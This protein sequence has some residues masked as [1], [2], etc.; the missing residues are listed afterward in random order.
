[1]KNTL[2]FKMLLVALLAT[3]PTSVLAQRTNDNAV[4]KAEDAFGSSVGDEQI[5]I[6]NANLVRGFSPVA[7]VIHVGI[8]AQ[9]YPFPAPTG[10]A[11]YRLRR[12]GDTALTSVNLSLG[13][14]GGVGAELDGQ[15]PLQGDRAGVIFGIGRYREVQPHLGSGDLTT[16]AL[17]GRL[18]P[19]DNV[20]ILPFW[21]QVRVSG[22][23][24]QSLIFTTTNDFLPARIA[25]DRF[26][27][28]KWSDYTGTLSNYGVVT[29]ADLDAFDISFGLFR[30][31]W[32]RPHRACGQPRGRGGWRQSLW[33]DLW[34]VSRGTQHGG[35]AAFA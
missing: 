27:G 22:E 20:E 23:R 16:M 13:P 25:R 33:L 14:W 32:N 7:A 15:L 29:K 1:M 34:R 24:S 28:Q 11:D 5:G 6:Y 31:L 21:S 30:S 19:A 12:A 3:A 2:R 18:R 35:R 10:I 17:S 26:L 9:G 4:K 8:S